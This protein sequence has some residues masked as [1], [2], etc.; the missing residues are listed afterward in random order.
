MPFVFSEATADFQAVTLQG[1]FTYRV[2]DPK[3][4]AS[5]LDHSVDRRLA[6]GSDDPR[7]LPD[8]LVH[9]I[10][11]LTR[12]IT[13]RLNPRDALVSS[14]AIVGEALGKFRQADAVTTLGADTDAG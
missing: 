3:R 8:R 4:L 5:L 13:Q 14:D 6:Y 9:T 12:T 1:Q 7:K 10:Q 11:T 2:A